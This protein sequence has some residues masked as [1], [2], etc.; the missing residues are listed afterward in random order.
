MGRPGSAPRRCPHFLTRGRS[1]AAAF[2]SHGSAPLFGQR[3]LA[4]SRAPR[5]PRAAARRG[6]CGLRS[7]RGGLAVHRVPPGAG[8]RGADCGTAAGAHQHAAGCAL[9]AGEPQGLRGA[10]P[11]LTLVLSTGDHEKGEM[12]LGER[13][14]S[15]LCCMPR[16]WAAPG[17]PPCSPLTIGPDREKAVS[18]D[19]TCGPGPLQTAFC[20]S[21]VSVIRKYAT[22][23]SCPSHTGNPC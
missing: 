6:P 4:V 13:G 9:R 20:I 10:R 3:L 19:T 18:R 2:C 16:L 14:W 8:E 23:M 5:A 15:R 1:L 17:T 12:G 7:G 22:L 11:T 21:S